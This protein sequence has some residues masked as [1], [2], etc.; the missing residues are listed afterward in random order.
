MADL[1]KDML[2]QWQTFVGVPQFAAYRYK[3]FFAYADEFHPER[4]LPKNSLLNTPT[5]ADPPFDSST[6][7]DDVRSVVQPFSVGP[8]NCIGMNLA[9]AEMRLVFARL[10]YNFDIGLPELDEGAKPFKFEEQKTF[11]LWE[12]EACI[13]KI[14]ERVW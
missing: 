2:T 9:Y 11:A 1:N 8:R 7:A 5:L 3:P 14:R 12:R 13:V 6:F 4:W 10:L